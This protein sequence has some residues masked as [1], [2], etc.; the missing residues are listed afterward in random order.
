M[1]SSLNQ[2][3]TCATAVTLNPQVGAANRRLERVASRV[4]R[5]RDDL[6]ERFKLG[7]RKA[8]YD[9]E[10]FEFEGG[11]Q[12]AL[13]KK[14]Y[15]KSLR[16][17]WKAEKEAP[18]LGFKDCSA[19]ERELTEMAEKSMDAEELE[20]RRQL[21]LPEFKALLD[22]HYTLREKEAIV[23]ILAAIGHGEAYAWLVS[24]EMLGMVKSTGARAALTMQVFEEAKH[25]VVLRELIRAFD[26]PVPRQSAWEYMMLEGVIKAKGLDKFFGMNVLIEGI[27]LSFFGMLSTYPGLDLLRRFHLDESRHTALPQNYFKEF[28]LSKQESKSPVAR[29]RR[30]KMLMPALALIPYLEEDL[31]V[32]GIDAF[33]FGGSVLRKVITLSERNG[34]YLPLPATTVTATLNM[35]FNGYCKVT[36]PNHVACDFMVAETTKGR[37]ERQVEETVFEPSATSEEAAPKKSA[38][39]TKKAAPKKA[40]A[41]RSAKAQAAPVYGAAQAHA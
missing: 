23:A 26:V 32:L 13:R 28:P 10:A 29:M 16:L 11:A 40:R 4:V 38:A 22:S 1:N 27:A 33:E 19:A 20:L 3:E 8:R 36:R 35:L 41:K 2:F 6:L 17:L 39:P 34:F 37:A 7:G 21:S 5:K 12:D 31:A 24:A 14:H 18:F 15:D 30:L 25:F 9:D